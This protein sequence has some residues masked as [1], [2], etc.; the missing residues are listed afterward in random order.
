MLGGKPYHIL[1]NHLGSP[2][3]VMNTES[4]DIALDANPTSACSLPSPQES[5]GSVGWLYG[6]RLPLVF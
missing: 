1:S 5:S 2:R 4:R 3:L 6:F